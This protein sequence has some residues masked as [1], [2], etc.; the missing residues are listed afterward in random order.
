[1]KE[2]ITHVQE[3]LVDQDDIQILTYQILHNIALYHP[4]ALLEV[5]DDL[6]R[7]IEK[8]FF[9]V[10]RAKEDVFCRSERK[11]QRREERRA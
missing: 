2:F 5:L 3:G 11:T 8:G 9:C 6:P 1:M 7:L 10:A 4:Q